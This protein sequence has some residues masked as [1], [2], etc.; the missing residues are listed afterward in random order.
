MLIRGN[1]IFGACLAFQLYEK[2][3][4]TIIFALRKTIFEDG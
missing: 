3:R 1:M 2:T 4:K